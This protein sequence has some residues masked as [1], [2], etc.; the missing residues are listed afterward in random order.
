[1][2][3]AAHEVTTKAETET[4]HVARVVG[5]FPVAHHSKMAAPAQNVVIV[6]AGNAAKH[7][8]TISFLKL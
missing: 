3:D 1:M 7:P 2:T 5:S 4:K 6:G 8:E